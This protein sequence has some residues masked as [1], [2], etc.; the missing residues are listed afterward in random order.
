MLRRLISIVA[1]TALCLM[2]LSFAAPMASAQGGGVYDPLQQY[3][4]P[5]PANETVSERNGRFITEVDRSQNQILGRLQQLNGLSSEEIVNQTSRGELE[6]FLGRIAEDEA[7]MQAVY[8]SWYNSTGGTSNQAVEANDNLNLLAGRRMTL[9]PIRQ[10]Y[11]ESFANVMNGLQDIASLLMVP[12]I[13][14]E[15]YSV[16]FVDPLRADVRYSQDLYNFALGFYEEAH[17]FGALDDPIAMYIWLNLDGGYDKLNYAFNATSEVIRTAVDHG[18]YELTSATSMGDFLVPGDDPYNALNF[19]ANDILSA[20]LPILSAIGRMTL[21]QEAEQLQVPQPEYQQ[22]WGAFMFYDPL[23][24]FYP[25]Y[26]EYSWYQEPEPPVNPYQDT[27]NYCLGFPDEYVDD[28]L[29][30]YGVPEEWW[31]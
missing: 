10:F 13:F 25:E 5:P 2:A 31:F 8:N 19:M 9:S 30:F 29:I 21:E 4:T 3:Q 15:G 7:K 28:C 17:N 22:D 6:G 1:M 20:E 27:I 26:Y 23:W 14:L 18:A 12:H 24:S 16:G 11:A